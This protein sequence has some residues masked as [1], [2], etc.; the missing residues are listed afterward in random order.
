MPEVLAR[1]GDPRRLQA[2][3]RAS[4]VWALGTIIFILLTGPAPFHTAEESWRVKWHQPAIYRRAT[5]CELTAT[6]ARSA[7]VT[8]QLQPEARVQPLHSLQ[9]AA[10]LRWAP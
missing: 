7:L 6:A 4:D 3:T 9:T 1:H 8:L 2:H 5:H 10:L